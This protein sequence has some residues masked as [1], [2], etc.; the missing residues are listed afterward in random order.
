MKSPELT[1]QENIVLSLIEDGAKL[2]EIAS[3]FNIKPQ[4]V[5]NWVVVIRRKLGV[6]NRAIKTSKMRIAEAE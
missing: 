1:E 4:S 2:K 3:R 5:K 6:A